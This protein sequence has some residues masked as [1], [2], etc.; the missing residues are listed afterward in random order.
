MREF[1]CIKRRHVLPV[2][3]ILCSVCVSGKSASN[4][5]R[6]NSGSTSSF[7]PVE[8]SGWTYKE[9]G[10]GPDEWPGM[11]QVGA[12][13]SPVDLD[14]KTAV[15]GH[16]ES[17]V[18]LNY[19]RK[20]VGNV[21]NNGH[22]LML[23]F[24]QPCEM[25]MAAGGLPAVYRLEQI[26]FHW[27]SEHTFQGKRCPLEMHMVHYDRQFKKLGDAVKF[28]QGLAVL[29]VLFYETKEPNTVLQPLLEFMPEV[30]QT[31][32]IPYKLSQHVTLQ[33]LLPDELNYFYRYAGSLTTPNCDESVVWTVLAQLVPIGVQQVAQFHKVQSH[34]EPLTSNFRP[35]QTV[36]KRQI[37][38]QQPSE[39]YQEISAAS[40]VY[41]SCFIVIVLSTFS[42]TH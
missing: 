19:D 42:I 27:R 32:G 31:E 12:R 33:N 22:T 18:L 5:F 16:F 25:V 1:N 6:L 39:R 24:E 3:C 10:N 23:T 9:G 4:S 2:C 40:S 15:P 38:L 29:A 7:L 14:P 17:L 28:N 8:G 34:H 36:N 37:Y 13:Q 41:E 21:T 11:C 30:S 20:T 35:I 26:H